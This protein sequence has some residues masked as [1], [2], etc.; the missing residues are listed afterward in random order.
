MT[1]VSKP[2]SESDIRREN[3]RL[4]A[5]VERLTLENTRLEHTRKGEVSVQA[6][7][8]RM[9]PPTFVAAVEALWIAS[10]G[11]GQ[12]GSAAGVWD[13]GER[14]GQQGKA[15]GRWQGGAVRTGSGQQSRGWGK[16]MHGGTVHK[17]GPMTPQVGSDDV[18]EA[19]KD[20]AARKLRALARDIMGSLRGMENAETWQKPRR[21]S[22]TEC[23]KWGDPDWS[24]CPRCGS[25][26][27]NAA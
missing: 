12:D 18:I 2:Q 1:T 4:R 21:C 8:L 20:R 19:V 3:L 6:E 13:A 5:A 24:Y 10:I 23:R 15:D 26:M 25:D 9:L 27:V 17:A 22:G 16:G 11:A 7:V 14:R